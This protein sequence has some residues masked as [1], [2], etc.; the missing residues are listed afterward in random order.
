MKIRKLALSRFVGLFGLLAVLPVVFLSQNR[1][2]HAAVVTVNTTDD[3]LN[4]DGDCSL[5]EA[6]IAANTDT[7][8]DACPTGSGADTINL[9]AGR[10]TLTVLGAGENA[11]ATGDLDI[12]GILLSAA[13]VRARPS[14]MATRLTACFRPA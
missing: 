11:A 7:A 4:S 8:V 2:A 6:I 13:L 5:R 14:W 1:A 10:Y 3:E 12:A 9:P